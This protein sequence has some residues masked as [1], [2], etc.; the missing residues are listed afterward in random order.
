MNQH[1]LDLIQGFGLPQALQDLNVLDVLEVNNIFV[2]EEG[3]GE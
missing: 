3:L 2:E 1:L